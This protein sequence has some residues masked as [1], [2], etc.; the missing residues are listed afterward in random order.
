MEWPEDDPAA[1]ETLL[2]ILHLSDSRQIPVV[3]ELEHLFRVAVAI[4]MYGLAPRLGLWPRAWCKTAVAALKVAHE[5]GQLAKLTWIGWVFGNRPVFEGALQRI[6]AEVG[7]DE[8][9]E[10]VD[11]AGARLDDFKYFRAMDVLG[12]LRGARALFRTHTRA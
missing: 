7:L 2:Q 3:F 12:E 10:L 4:D 5:D 8:E 6:L 11:S 1:I 9:G